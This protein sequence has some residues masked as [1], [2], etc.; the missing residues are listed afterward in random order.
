MPSTVADTTRFV[1]AALLDDIDVEGCLVVEIEGESIALFRHAGEVF[2]IDNRC[3]HMG[4][5]LHQGS[6]HCGILTCHWHHARFDLA[7]GGT[8]DPWADDVRSYPVRVENGEIQIDL[9]P[10]ATPATERYAAR[11]S[12]GMRRSLSLL[13]AKSVIGLQGADAPDSV[14]LT[15]GAEFGVRYARAGWSSGL[16]I[17]TAMANILPALAPDDRPRALY[18]GLIHVARQTSGQAPAI[19]LDPLSTPETRPHIFKTWFREFLEVRDRDAAER[20]LQT[21]IRAGLPMP[22]IADM[23]F[24]AATDHVYLNGGH[25]LDFVNKAFELL[26]LIGWEHATEVLPSLIPELASAR[27][28]E[29]TSGWRHPIDLVALLTAAFAELPRLLTQGRDLL[30]SWQGRSALVETL[31]QDD[32]H[33]SVEGLKAALASGATPEQLAGTVAIA[34][35]RRIAQFRTSNEFGDW[36]TVLHTFTYANA[37]HQAMRRAPSQE[38]LR[39]VF[40]AALSVYLDR[41]LNMP[42]SPLPQGSAAE[43]PPLSHLLEML[44]RQQQVPQA[45]QFVSDWLASGR[46]DAEL[47]ATMGVALLREDAEFHTFQMVEAGFRQY[48]ALRGAPE[49]TVMLVAIARYLAA[50]SPTSRAT[51]QT[52][53]T[54]LR[55]YKGEMLFT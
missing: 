19:P 40:D 18:Q 28:S 4:F 42:P 37:V 46:S 3:P 47:L 25:T 5:P 11:L 12:E 9:A 22:A 45:A 15:V 52:Y 26:D 16:T 32:P 34:A 6:V 13:I 54:A 14:A 39:G 8:F 36:I 41:F 2:A 43:C 51:G 35:A 49:G 30:G 38:L 48:R 24:T 17:L 7:S 44:N 23:L 21:A 33:T 53:Q 10:P 20:T 27:R 29:E 55:L 31:L 1:R 50:H